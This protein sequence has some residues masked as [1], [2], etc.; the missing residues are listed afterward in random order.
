[1]KPTTDELRKLLGA[2]C[3]K[4]ASPAS[5]PAPIEPSPRPLWTKPVPKLVAASVL[6]MPVFGIAG[7]FLIRG[8]SN[9]NQSQLPSST[10]PQISPIAPNDATAQL[11]QENASLKA[12]AALDGQNRI[13]N[14]LTK[15]D[16]QKQNRKIQ[17]P[18]LT[19]P[20]NLPSTA[21]TTPSSSVAIQSAPPKLT[22]TSISRPESVPTRPRFTDRSESA[23]KPAPTDPIQV[24]QRWQQL[25]NIGSYGGKLS[26]TS[27]PEWSTANPQAEQAILEPKIASIETTLSTHSETQ[28]VPQSLSVQATNPPILEEAESRILNA[29]SPQTTLMAGSTSSGIVTTSLVLDEIQNRESGRSSNRSSQ[30]QFTVVLTQPLKD[31]SG[32]IVMP[33]NTHLV[34]QVNQVSSTG[35]IQ[36]TAIAAHWNQNGTSRSVRLPTNAIQIRGKNGQPL[37]AHQSN[38]GKE[39]TAL[40]ARQ[41]LLGAVR[42]AADQLTQSNT[43]IEAANGTTIVTQNNGRSNLLAGALKGGT[44]AVLRS[45]SERNQQAIAAMQNRSAI[46][47]L[48]A[49]EAVQV[50]VNQPI[51]FRT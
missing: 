42:G 23:Q 9:S 12:K 26:P 7:A 8:Q 38:K 37:F 46:R 39:I 13:E 30:E 33:A 34:V 51:Q 11:R 48:E 47:S 35:R 18:S 27:H 17:K 5:S 20:K 19:V 31:E 24:E 40:D 45:I 44:D 22:T 10:E 50:F 32:A 16:Q 25:A 41:F 43:Q 14:R 36:S 2:P 15:Q 28:E 6:L 21:R 29:P 3:S 1:M 49:G 4:E